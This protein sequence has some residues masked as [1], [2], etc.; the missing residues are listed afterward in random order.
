M[1][2]SKPLVKHLKV[3]ISG[4]TG[5]EQ[6]RKETSATNSH[7]GFSELSIR[8]LVSTYCR[9]AQR[10]AEMVHRSVAAGV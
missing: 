3:G 4:R 8:G 5:E 9:G 10:R 2:L 1:L 6:R 7:C